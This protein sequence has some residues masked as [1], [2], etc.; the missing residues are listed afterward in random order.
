MQK[1]QVIC[2]T[3]VSTTYTKVDMGVEHALLISSTRF[4][5]SIVESEFVSH[6]LILRTSPLNSCSSSLSDRICVNR[7][8]CLLRVEVPAYSLECDVDTQERHTCN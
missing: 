2:H 6:R 7:Y 4:Q 3:L 8:T 5:L 1:D